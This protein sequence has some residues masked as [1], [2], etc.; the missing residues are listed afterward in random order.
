MRE[1]QRVRDKE[2]EREK[3][4]IEKKKNRDRLRKG[5]ILVAVLYI[6]VSVGCQFENWKEDSKT[7]KERCEFSSS[8]D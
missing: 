8:N 2:R 1:R 5:D 7:R 3:R 4:E 6:N